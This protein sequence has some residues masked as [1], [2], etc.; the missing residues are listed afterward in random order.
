MGKHALEA[1]CR[2]HFKLLLF[3]YLL[4][5]KAFEQDQVCVPLKL[6]VDP[7]QPSFGLD[8]ADRLMTSDAFITHTSDCIHNQHCRQRRNPRPYVVW[9]CLIV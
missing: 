4:S 5:K 3:L 9:D 6:A 2:F 8:Q 1:V 7:A